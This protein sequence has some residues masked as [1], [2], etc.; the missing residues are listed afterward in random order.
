MQPPQILSFEGRGGLNLKPLE[1]L[2]SFLSLNSSNDQTQIKWYFQTKE[3]TI[4]AVTK[5]FKAQ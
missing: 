2:R 3:S 4:D 1:T 5:L